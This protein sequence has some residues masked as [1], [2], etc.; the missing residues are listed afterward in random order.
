MSVARVGSSFPSDLKCAAIMGRYWRMS[1][2]NW[3]GVLAG[4]LLR[5]VLDSIS[6]QGDDSVQMDVKC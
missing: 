6:N 4:P 3:L 5:A 1:S 2:A